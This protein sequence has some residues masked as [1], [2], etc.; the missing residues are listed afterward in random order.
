MKKNKKKNQKTAVKETKT[1][2]TT[3]V[4]KEDT[5]AAENTEK[6]QKS[7]EPEQKAKNEDTIAKADLPAE[8]MPVEPQAAAD[9]TASEEKP[10]SKKKEKPAKV[11]REKP[12]LVPISIGKTNKEKF[13]TSN[14]VFVKF[15]AAIPILGA[16][17]TLKNGILISAVMLI[18]VVFLNIVMYP[19]SKIIPKRFRHITEFIVAGILIA[20]QLYAASIFIPN[21][22]TLCAFYL[23]LTA[24]SAIPMIETKFYGTRHGFGRTILLAFL[25]ACGFAFA[26]LLF[27]VIREVIGSGLL[28]ERPMPYASSIK[29]PFLTIPAGAFI[30]LGLIAALFK[31]MFGTKVQENEE[32]NK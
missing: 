27:S 6:V 20:P 7:A 4:L 17:L 1:T 23:P 15:I 26:A 28:Y 24:I 29:L 10:A 2:E 8:E 19:L 18:T 16:A 31:K 5:E 12:E 11:K 13:F 22:T 32:D 21:V 3:E 30:L 14:P 9:E 25:D